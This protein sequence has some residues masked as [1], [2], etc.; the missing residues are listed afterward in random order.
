MK[1]NMTSKKTTHIRVE[2]DIF[3]LAR[4]KLNYYSD[5]EIYKAGVITL[6]K[7]NKMGKFVY[8]NVWN[9]NKKKQ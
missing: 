1:K 3:N 5:K 4:S 8:G 6:I 7:Y 2:K 9:K